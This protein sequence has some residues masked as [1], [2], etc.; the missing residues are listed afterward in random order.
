MHWSFSLNPFHL[1]RHENNLNDCMT[2]GLATHYSWDSVQVHFTGCLLKH[3]TKKGRKRC[4]FCSAH[5]YLVVVMGNKMPHV[6]HMG[7]MTQGK[8]QFSLAYG[9]LPK[10]R[11]LVS[12]RQHNYTIKASERDL[13]P[14]HV[15]RV[16][17][18][19]KERCTLLQ[20]SF[21]PLFCC[22]PVVGL[23]VQD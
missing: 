20:C 22:L 21:S 16:C 4:C 19:S 12:I 14:G 9:L 11:A 18:L 15:A 8:G 6:L 5:E 17:L 23:S 10:W 13:V 3:C 1:R 2:F 7:E